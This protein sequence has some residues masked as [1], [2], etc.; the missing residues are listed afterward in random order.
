MV[1]AEGDLKLERLRVDRRCV[2]M[3][4]ETEP[5]FRGLRVE[6]EAELTAD[7]VRA[8]RLAI[9]RRYLGDAASQRYVEQ[10]TRPGT[11]VRVQLSSA[12]SWDLRSIL[13]S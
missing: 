10:R 2:F 7:G 1:I 9:A 8:A 6:G 3:A 4:F 5:P 13:P 12:R 11:L